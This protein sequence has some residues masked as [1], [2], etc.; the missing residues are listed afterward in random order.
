MPGFSNYIEL[1]ALNAALRGQSFP[2]ITAVYA[3]L[4]LDD[5]GRNGLL[6]AAVETTRK[7][8]EFNAA[9]VV[10]G[11]GRCTLLSTVSWTNVST[12][13]TYTHVSLWD[14]LTAGNC[15]GTAL[16]DT[17]AVMTAGDDF[18]LTELIFTLEA[19]A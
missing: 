14:H 13:E 12:Q 5:P 10:S 15:V 9:S 1:A 3:K 4:H 16:L 6:S 18:D 19:A 7:Q 2:T 17:P 8:V 11:N